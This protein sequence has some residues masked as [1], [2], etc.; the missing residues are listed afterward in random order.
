MAQN[1]ETTTYIIQMRDKFTMGMNKATMASER[2]NTST[3][4]IKKNTQGLSNSFSRFGF[5]A[6][7]ALLGAA[8]AMGRLG[9][10]VIKTASS[11]EVIEK[12]LDVMTGRQGLGAGL[13]DWAKE[14]SRTTIITFNQTVTSMRKLLAYGITASNAKPLTALL[15]EIAAGVGTDR[16]PYLTL[17]LGQV[18]SRGRLMG[19]E[20]RQFREHGVDIISELAKGLKVGTPMV[21]D[22]VTKGLVS[23]DMVVAAMEQMVGP[24]GRFNKMLEDMA[25]TTS[26][27][28]NIIKSTWT[29][30]M[31]NLGE[32]LLP[33]VNN[34]L[35]YVT[36]LLEKLSRMPWGDYANLINSFTD[37][38]KRLGALFLGDQSLA[39]LL[40]RWSLQITYIVA[41]V[42]D[43]ITTI[44]T[45]IKHEFS[46]MGSFF[47]NIW[48][49]LKAEWANDF[50][51]RDRAMKAISL[52]DPTTRNKLMNDLRWR[53]I[54]RRTD[55]LRQLAAKPGAG[56]ELDT[57]KFTSTGFL[58]GGATAEKAKKTRTNRAIGTG[59]RDIIINIGNLVENM[60]NY[61]NSTD[62]NT[63]VFKEKMIRALTTVVNDVSLTV[64]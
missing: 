53:S 33:L 34:I 15:S 17:A 25:K 35:D 30:A 46:D 59:A 29:I 48:K 14:F 51:A 37:S 42:T 10:S 61:G 2:F 6:K 3:S 23:F 52:D 22:M 16:L 50:E 56:T 64:R 62:E 21:E 31:A 19:T 4:R 12:A 63:E 58:S 40:Y 7:A 39:G 36:P 55:Y 44:F 8:Y 24:G 49:T 43:K 47:S 28:F 27:K 26:G 20:L 54:Q 11:F 32:A 1:T 45:I 38:L 18:K 57:G 5:I 13:M 60:N 9:L 41:E